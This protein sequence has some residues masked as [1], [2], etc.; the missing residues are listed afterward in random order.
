MWPEH[1]RAQVTEAYES[2][3]SYVSLACS[4]TNS[5]KL[6][7]FQ[8]GLQVSPCLRQEKIPDFIV[9]R[10]IIDHTQSFD[11]IGFVFLRIASLDETLHDKLTQRRNIVFVGDGIDMDEGRRAAPFLVR[12]ERE[13]LRCIE[14]VLVEVADEDS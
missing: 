12:K 6:P 8:R 7:F 1:Q 5:L 13:G 10:A 3:S 11:E 4:K 2:S 9:K 14:H